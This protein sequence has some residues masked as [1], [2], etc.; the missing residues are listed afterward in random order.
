MNF[1]SFLPVISFLLLP[2]PSFS[3]LPYSFP[4]SISSFPSYF[5]RFFLFLFYFFFALSVVSLF[6]IR[7]HLILFV[8]HLATKNYYLQ[9]ILGT[10]YRWPKC[11]ITL[12]RLRRCRFS[13]TLYFFIDNCL[14]FSFLY[15][16]QSMKFATVSLQKNKKINE[17]RKF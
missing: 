11:E 17:K 8:T 10:T 15:K 4:S 1:I 14:G 13:I 7:Y 2:S 16:F 12:F 6:S 5:V 9:L 3:F